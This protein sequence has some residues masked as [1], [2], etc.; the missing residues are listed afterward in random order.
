M[1]TLNRFA[2]APQ[3][4]CCWAWSGPLPPSKHEDPSRGRLALHVQPSWLC[5][6]MWRISPGPQFFLFNSIAFP[7]CSAGM[8]GHGGCEVTLVSMLSLALAVCLEFLSGL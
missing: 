7:L 8:E 5:S 2:V 3:H 6:F 1:L 4:L